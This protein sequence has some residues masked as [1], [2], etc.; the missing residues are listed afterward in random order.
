MI[1]LENVERVK[2]HAAPEELKLQLMTL[3]HIRYISIL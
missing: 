3:N 1:R 2:P